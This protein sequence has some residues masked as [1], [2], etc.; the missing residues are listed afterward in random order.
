MRFFL[1]LF[2]FTI[3]SVE[4]RPILPSDFGKVS[5]SE[6]GLPI[7]RQGTCLVFQ[8]QDSVY[9]LSSYHVAYS[10]WSSEFEH[11]VSFSQNGGKA[12]LEWM[13]SDWSR[14]MIL[15]RLKD[16][17]K[18]NYLDWSEISWAENDT[19]K[20]VL[21]LGYPLGSDALN[22]AYGTRVESG[23]VKIPLF[24]FIDKFVVIEDL[25]SEVG[26]SGGALLNEAGEYLGLLSHQLYFEDKF[27]TIAIPPNEVFDWTER[28]LRYQ[29]NRSFF[30][31]KPEELEN[32]RYALYLRHLSVK[33]EEYPKG[34]AKITFKAGEHEFE[35]LI[36]EHL[37]MKNAERFFPEG[38]YS[39]L[40]CIPLWPVSS[41]DEIHL[42]RKGVE[43][44]RFIFRPELFSDECG[45]YQFLKPGANEKDL[46]S[47]WTKLQDAWKNS[48][49]QSSDA[50]RWYDWWNTILSLAA[51]KRSDGDNLRDG[52]I[53]LY[54]RTYVFSRMRD[55]E[56]DVERESLI[57]KYPHVM[58]ELESLLDQLIAVHSK[59]VLTVP[60]HS[61]SGDK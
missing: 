51:K 53:P 35:N 14:G 21:A 29:V 48:H 61:F 12:S 27:I 15:L 37:R 56:F 17:P 24:V 59:Q 50:P 19:S 25:A 33:I 40:G 5:S 34:A 57:K 23:L 46:F 26:F 1:I 2:F 43:P 11:F 49:I 45:Y 31:V 42:F 28:H 20:N 47:A 9:C 38:E 13:A 4:A 10:A 16:P 22:E 60:Y 8:Y 32:S 3:S 18:R 41:I 55:K 30:Y 39:L 6:V 44:I 54:L 52:N 36:I 58:I 7:A